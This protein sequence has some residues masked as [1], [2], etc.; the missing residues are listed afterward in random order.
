MTRQEAVIKI[1]KIT[2][3]IGELKYQLDVDDEVGFE[4]LDPEWK[5]IAEWTQEVC[6]YMELDAP[7]QVVRLIAN[8]GFTDMVEEYVRSRRKEIGAKE[9]KILDDYV[10][11]M[12]TLSSFCDTRSEEQKEKYG[13]LIE[14]LANERVAALLQRAVDAGI[15]DRHYQPA[16]QTKPLQ[17]K[18]IAYAVSNLCKLHSPYVLFEKQWHRENG[19]RFNTCR[20]PKRNTVCYEETRALYPE[21]DFAGFEP[22][23]EAETFYVPQSEEVIRVMYEDL[24]K[25]EYI[26]PDTTFDVF[27]SIFNKARFVKPVEWT[28]NQ[29]QLAYFV[30]QAFNR[31][32]KKNLW[33]KGECCFRIDGKTP[34]KASLVTGYGWLKRAGWMDRYDTRLK[35]ICDQFNHAEN[36]A[37][38]EGHKDG[39]PIHTGRCIFHSTHSDEDKYAM[40]QALINGEYIDPDTTF[41][42]FNGILDET[43]FC[44]PVIWIKK[45]SQLMY[46]VHSAFKADNPSDVWVKCVHCFRLQDGKEPNRQSMDS[47]YRFI[48]RKGLLETYDTELKRIADEYTGIKKKDA[49]TS[50]TMGD[51]D[52]HSNIS[53]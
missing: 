15:L 50:N 27:N 6:R 22:V 26:A 41:S 1:A 20:V 40:Y 44:Q 35:A 14:P 33:I 38:K 34:H 21:V 30:H 23:H 28:K 3:I 32:N 10:K 46:F 5:H 17:L 2:R 11:H 25:Y 51:N 37:S 12:R 9:A 8:I 16:P 47:K 18:V 42:I 13:D 19:K 31:F 49:N 36:A 7:P 52:N 53:P 39:L 4:A 48:V 43:K 45:Q 24:L 29:R